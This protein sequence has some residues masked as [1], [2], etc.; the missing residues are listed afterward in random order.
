MNTVT[1]ILL[2]YTVFAIFHGYRCGFLRIILGF[3]AM[4]LTIVL[5]LALATPLS[6]T[7]AKQTT[8]DDEIEAMLMESL[9][10]YQGEKAQELSKDGDSLITM[11][12]KDYVVKGDSFQ[13]MDE[14]IAKAISS[15]IL[16]WF[17]FIL[18]Y[19][20]LFIIF[21]ILIRMINQADHVPVLHTINRIAGIIIALLKVYINVNVFFLIVSFAENTSL[22]KTILQQISENNFIYFLY[23]N[24]IFPKLFEIISKNFLS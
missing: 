13:K 6:K 17:S 20:V 15:T 14:K 16:Q 18:L 11:L 8:I 5:A 9:S 4:V 22:G 7:I 1:I 19:I 2:I 21:R 3:V 12:I 24:N 10:N 23:Q